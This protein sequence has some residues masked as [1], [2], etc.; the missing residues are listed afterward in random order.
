MSENINPV[1]QNENQ[2]VDDLKKS[3]NAAIEEASLLLKNSK[4]IEVCSLFFRC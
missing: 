1:N 4:A 2:L 3:L